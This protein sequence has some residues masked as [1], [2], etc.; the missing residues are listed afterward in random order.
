MD[1][2]STQIREDNKD[3][4]GWIEA[5][6]GL[7]K[8]LAWLMAVVLILL[9]GCSPKLDEAVAPVPNRPATKRFK[10]KQTILRKAVERVLLKKGFILDSEH[11]TAQHL[12]T[13][14]LQEGYFRSLVQADIKPLA[15]RKSE[16]TLFIRR[17]RR[18]LR[19]EIW[20]AQD[21]I[22]DRVYHD[23]FVD[24]DVEIYRVIYDDT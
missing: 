9:A 3:G 5:A 17:E 14:W 11:C 24:V 7:K 1:H 18:E 6:N 22:G 2:L 21:V 13:E 19:K 10:V 23:Y 20:H 8:S 12:R 16:L 15:K 4:S